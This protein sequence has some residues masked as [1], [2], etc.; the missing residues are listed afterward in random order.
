MRAIFR[1][2]TF[3]AGRADADRVAFAVAMTF[4]GSAPAPVDSRAFARFQ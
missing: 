2:E 4:H 3:A 1:A